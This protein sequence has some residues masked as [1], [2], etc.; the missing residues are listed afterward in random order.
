L[1]AKKF[2]FSEKSNF[3]ASQPSLNTPSSFDSS[4][5]VC[6]YRATLEVKG[7]QI[8]MNSLSAPQQSSPMA[9]HVE[10][11]VLVL[12]PRLDGSWRG[13][14]FAYFSSQRDALHARTDPMP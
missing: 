4:G 3:W 1:R 13:F 6:Y 8:L 5:L 12:A 11:A 2:D 7:I 10:R 9:A 14:Y